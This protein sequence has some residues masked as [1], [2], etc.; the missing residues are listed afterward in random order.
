MTTT[1]PKGTTWPFKSKTKGRRRK[2]ITEA[3]TITWPIIS[4]HSITRP[5]ESTDTV[6]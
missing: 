5:S 3:Q 1:C 2:P 6:T 4:G